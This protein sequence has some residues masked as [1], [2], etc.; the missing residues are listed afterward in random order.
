GVGHQH[1][2]AAHGAVFDIRLLGYRQ[3]EGQIDGF[4]TMRTGGVLALEKVH[5]S[6]VNIMM[7]Q[8]IIPP[9]HDVSG[10]GPL[11]LETGWGHPYEES[12]SRPIR[13][14][15]IIFIELWIAN[16]RVRHTPMF[17]NTSV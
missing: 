12:W 13:R 5:M 6:I 11:Y 10:Q 16:G 17:P 15:L 7:I 1:G 8:P 9:G 2:L 14:S 3:V 4:P